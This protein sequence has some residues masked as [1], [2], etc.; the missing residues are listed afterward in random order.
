MKKVVFALFAALVAVSMFAQPSHQQR[1]QLDMLEEEITRE[2]IALVK[3]EGSLYPDYSQKITA[4]QAENDSVKQI[5]PP[6]DSIAAAKRA[7]ETR[8]LV[9]KNQKQIIHLTTASAEAYKNAEIEA[10]IAE[11]KNKI[12]VLEEQRDRIFFSAATTDEIPREMNHCTTRR[13][14]N[15]N[16]IRREELVIQKVENT[17]NGQS[18]QAITP[19]AD[20]AGFMVILHNDYALPIQFSIAGINGGDKKSYV[21]RKGEKTKVYLIPG[22]YMVTFLRG[23]NTI[24]HP[25]VLTIDGSVHNYMG[26][27]CFGFAYMPRY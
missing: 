19:V 24:G 20:S 17:L 3:L 11:K 9:E 14:H 4:L 5:V 15:A 16:H 10:K 26:E 22:Q 21:L 6:A 23:G 8:L 7:L 13:R 2:K 1:K 27:D 25:V 18:G 12:R